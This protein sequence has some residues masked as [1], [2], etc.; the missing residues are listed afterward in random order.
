M[1]IHTEA[2]CALDRRIKSVKTLKSRYLWQRACPFLTA[3]TVQNR[4]PGP[5]IRPLWCR[6][7]FA[8]S[9]G[10]SFPERRLGLFS[11]GGF[12]DE[13]FRFL[14]PPEI[15]WSQYKLEFRDCERISWLIWSSPWKRKETQ[16]VK[17]Y[18]GKNSQNSH[19]KIANW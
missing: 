14:A 12:K 2:C 11:T 6:L 17:N 5:S 10:G 16:S 7:N 1:P 4:Q 8:F 9:H 13:R 3:Y 18:D 19:Q 15:L